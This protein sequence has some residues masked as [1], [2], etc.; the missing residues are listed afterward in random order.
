MENETEVNKP[1][2]LD[3]LHNICNSH[4]QLGHAMKPCA[5]L[6]TLWV[7]RDDVYCCEY[8]YCIP[9]SAN[10]TR[11]SVHYDIVGV[12]CLPLGGTVNRWPSSLPS[13]S[14]QSVCLW[15]QIASLLSAST[16]SLE[17]TKSMGSNVNVHVHIFLCGCAVMISTC[18][19]CVLVIH[20]VFWLSSLYLAQYKCSMIDSY[21]STIT[22]ACK[23]LCCN[24]P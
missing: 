12:S 14:L 8:Y 20:F 23:G 21:I 13:R 18:P 15:V 2:C 11:D 6:K 4:L 10:W 24:L 22:G 7:H 19:F 9:K 5:C 3:H 1:S 16:L 17:H